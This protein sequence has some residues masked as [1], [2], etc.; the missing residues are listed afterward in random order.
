M[1]EFLITKENANQRA[2]KFIKKYLNEAPLSF[3][4]K[5]FRKKD[6]KVNNKWIKENYILKEG[7]VLKVYISDEKIAEFNKP[8]D[9]SEIKTK[10]NLDIVYE[11][12]NILIVNKRKGILIHGDINEKRR[13]LSNEVLTYLYQKGEFKNDG[14]SFIPSPVHRLDRNTSGLVIF[15]KNLYSS[16]AMLELLKDHENILKT[17]L[18]LS[19]NKVKEEEGMID[20]P[21]IKNEKN[22]FVKVGSIDSGA[23]SAKTLFKVI[24]ENESYTLFKASLITGRTHQLRVHFASICCPIVGDEKYGDFSKNKSFEKEFNY[25]TQFLIAYKISFKEVTGEL[26]YLSN[27]TFKANISEKE[28]KIL[29]ELGLKVKDI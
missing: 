11:D 18:V 28:L 16:Q 9:I 8:I 2:D 17:Y 6:I 29:K 24:D 10:A 20:L 23:K 3:I 12:E 19:F 26:S 22:G 15:A 21:L 1:K 14:K 5:T 27:K 4:Y 25:R 7:D 13:T